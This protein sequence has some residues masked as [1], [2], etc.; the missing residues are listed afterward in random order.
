MD[1]NCKIGS[2]FIKGDLHKISPNGLLLSQ[3]ILRQ[4][5]KIINGS[6]VCEGLI[7][8]CRKIK[9]KNDGENIERSIIDLVITSNNLFNQVIKM[10]VFEQRENVL[11]RVIRNKN[12]DKKVESDHNNILTELNVEIPPPKLQR[13][14]FYNLKT[15]MVRKFSKILL[16]IQKCYHL[17][18]IAMNP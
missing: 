6:K 2:E 17:F 8:R 11:H 7:T 3:I 9:K 10:K 15:R 4:N 12:D 18:S 13:K 5:L 16:Q 14:E 1:A